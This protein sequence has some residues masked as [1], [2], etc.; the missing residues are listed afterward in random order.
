MFFTLFCDSAFFIFVPNSFVSRQRLDGNFARAQADG[1]PMLRPPLNRSQKTKGF[2]PG[3][4]GKNQTAVVSD[5]GGQHANQ[6]RASAF[7]G[8]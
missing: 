8:I 6:E 3:E 4:I 7:W 5:L 1:L 2:K